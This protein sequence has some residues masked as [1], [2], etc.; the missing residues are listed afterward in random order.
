MRFHTQQFD[1]LL[2]LA[3]DAHSRGKDI[4][5]IGWKPVHD[6]ALH[7]DELTKIRFNGEGFDVY[8][9][10]ALAEINVS[11]EQALDVVMA[12]AVYSELEHE[13]AQAEQPKMSP[14]LKGWATR[15]AAAAKMQGSTKGDLVKAFLLREQGATTAELKKL[16]GWPSVNAV[17]YARKFGFSLERA[18]DPK[19][20][21]TRYFCAPLGGPVAP[22]IVETE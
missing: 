3:L 4:S 20:G 22:E 16:T 7:V 5:G 19:T 2:Q 14:Q 17:H 12:S 13:P 11:R 8:R 1:A 18:V 6:V 15:R 21:H 9:A 10:H